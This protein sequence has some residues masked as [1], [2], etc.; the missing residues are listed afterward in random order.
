MVSVAKNDFI[1]LEFVGRIKDTKEIFDTNSKTEIEKNKLNFPSKPYIICVGKGMSIA[2]LDK[3]LEGKE[4]GKD[5]ELELNPEE[6]FGKR[7]PAMVRMIP[8]KVF[9]EQKI[10]P[11]KGMQLSLDGTIVKVVSISGGRVLVDFNNP[12]SGKVVI[13]TYKILRKIEDQ[14]EKVNALQDFFF[15]KRFDFTINDK[16]VLFKVESPTIKFIEMMA[17]PFEDILGL[18][19]KVEITEKKKEEKGEVGK[20]ESAT[21][22]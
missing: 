9:I 1:E 17:K 14:N 8:L 5:Y 20:N 11:Q 18:K 15:R 6:A 16:E 12:L 13:Y 22:S 21:K 4:V 2:G 7:N 19:I 10:M 3:A